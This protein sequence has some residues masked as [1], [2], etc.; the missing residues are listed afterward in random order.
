MC[1]SKSPEAGISTAWS[2][3]RYTRWSPEQLGRGEG[4]GRCQ[5]RLVGRLDSEKL[6]HEFSNWRRLGVG[7]RLV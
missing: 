1:P 2:P 4:M 3:P 5:I 6:E 7:E